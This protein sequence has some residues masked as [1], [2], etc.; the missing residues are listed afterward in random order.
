MICEKVS[1]KSSSSSLKSCQQGKLTTD[2]LLKS[3][4]ALRVK[5]RSTATHLLVASCP[6]G[7]KL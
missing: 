1:M 5:K 3:L 6:A 4:R 7:I 2:K